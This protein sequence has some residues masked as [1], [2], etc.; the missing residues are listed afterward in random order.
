MSSN[1]TK[2]SSVR[3]GI[4]DAQISL[5]VGLRSYMMKVYNYMFLALSVTGLVAY[6]ASQSL[7]LLQFLHGG[8]SFVLLIGMLIMAYML[9]TRIFRMSTTAGL[10]LFFLFSALMGLSL[11]YVFLAYTGTSIVR[12]FFVAAAT[13]GS[14]SLYGYTTKKDLTSMGSFLIMG[15]WGLILASL[16]NMFLQSSAMSFIT[17]LLGVLIFTGLTAYDTQKIKQIY[18]SGDDAGVSERKAILSAF[19][20]SLDF[21]NLFLYM[22]RFLGDRK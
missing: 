1:Y 18:F 7:P 15:L 13:F 16:V 17:S 9:P 21:I 11:S 12:T 22:L 20:L 14:M 19:I 4:Y 6:Y 10:G 3:A 5:D 2:K 8:F